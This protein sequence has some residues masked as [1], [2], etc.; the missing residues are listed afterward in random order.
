MK[1]LFEFNFKSFQIKKNTKC[2][3]EHSLYWGY[4]FSISSEVISSLVFS[5]NQDHLPLYNF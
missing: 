4:Q 1:S 2:L 3:L 5:F